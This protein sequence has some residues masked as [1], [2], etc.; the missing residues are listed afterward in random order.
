MSDLDETYGG[1]SPVAVGKRLKL[2]RELLGLKQV[3]FARR[4]ELAANTYNQLEAGRNYPSVD[5]MFRLCDTYDLDMNW[6]LC[7]DPSSLKHSLADA[8]YQTYRLRQTKT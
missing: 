4:V 3:E 8:I 6:L 2:V 1:R 5:A 7:G